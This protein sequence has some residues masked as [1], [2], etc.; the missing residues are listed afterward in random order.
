MGITARESLQKLLERKEQ[1]IA[2]LEV[3]L[4]EARAYAEALRE[5]IRLVSKG[6]I[7]NGS[8]SNS[9]APTLRPNTLLFQ[10]RE[11]LLKHGKS[12]YITDLLSAVGR[13]VDPKQRVS[14]AGTLSSYVREGKIF[15]KTA[16][17]TFGLLEFDLPHVSPPIEAAAM[18]ET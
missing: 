9:T 14:L 18:E 10:V 8:S 5:S 6:E 11:A 17:N 13:P 7:Q 4:C 15:S 16:P 3:R 12:M 2:D 1:E